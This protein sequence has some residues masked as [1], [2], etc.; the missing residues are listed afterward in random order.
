MVN[1][2]EERD[3]A[4]TELVAAVTLPFKVTSP[5]PPVDVPRRGTV[6]FTKPCRASYVHEPASSPPEADT[7]PPPREDMLFA[8]LDTA[9]RAST[10]IEPSPS[11]MSASSAM[12]LEEEREEICPAPTAKVTSRASLLEGPVPDMRA[13]LLVRRISNVHSRPLVSFTTE[14]EALT[15]KG[16]RSA[17]VLELLP[18]LEAKL[19]SLTWSMAMLASWKSPSGGTKL[20]TP[21]LTQRLC[22][23]QGWNAGASTLDPSPI[24]LG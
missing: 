3:D 9:A 16:S 12:P 21:S 5:G 14:R 2:D 13:V 6:H 10:L 18:P 20:R 23:T 15:V 11:A 8:L 4:S 24:G 22:L 17:P 19:P 1:T 7:E